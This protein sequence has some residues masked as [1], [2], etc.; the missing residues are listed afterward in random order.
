A[1]LGQPLDVTVPVQ[2]S[3]DEDPAQT[4]F[5]ADVFYGDG[6]RESGQITTSVQSGASSQM[7]QVRIRTSARVDEPVV[8]VYLKSVCGQK[9]SK[10]YV[11]LADLASEVTP[12]VAGLV[13]AGREEYCG[14]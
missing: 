13:R 10:R 11:L 12:P 6:H 2:T 3:G 5:E 7:V 14:L 1:L 8:T 9:T 4:C